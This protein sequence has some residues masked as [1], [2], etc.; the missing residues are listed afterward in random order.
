MLIAI[1]AKRDSVL[2]NNCVGNNVIII[3]LR[4]FTEREYD[5]HV[6]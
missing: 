4:L 3:E 2:V 6:T 5:L 1:I